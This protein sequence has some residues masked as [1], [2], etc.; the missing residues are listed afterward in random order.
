MACG[1]RGHLCSVQP[2]ADAKLFP[3]HIS[4]DVLFEFFH[5]LNFTSRHR[6]HYFSGRDNR[7][8]VCW[9]ALPE[10]AE[11]RWGSEQL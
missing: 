7:H 5:Y 9:L 3:P 6:Q 11:S 1:G 2:Y 8:M 4:F 10:I